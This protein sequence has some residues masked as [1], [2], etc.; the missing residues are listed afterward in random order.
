MDI[1]KNGYMYITK[2]GVNIGEGNYSVSMRLQRS[3]VDTK[4]D[5]LLKNSD[6]LTVDFLVFVDSD[7]ETITPDMSC[8]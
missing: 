5:N 7:Y 6:D 4:Y 3:I 1:L 8:D 2:M